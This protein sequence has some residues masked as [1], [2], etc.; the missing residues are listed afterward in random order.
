MVHHAGC[1]VYRYRAAIQRHVATKAHI[2]EI[3]T[4]DSSLAVEI[5]Q[6]WCTKEDEEKE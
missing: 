4:V 3:V 5:V 1:V 6:R 2:I